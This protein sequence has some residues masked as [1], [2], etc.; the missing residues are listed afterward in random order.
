MANYCPKCPADSN[1][2]AHLVYST[3]DGDRAI[4]LLQLHPGEPTDDIE[5]TLIGSSLS[6]SKGKQVGYTALSYVWGDQA[7]PQPTILCNGA[8]LHIT[9]NLGAALRTLRRE[10]E[11]RTLWIDQICINQADLKERSA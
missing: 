4:R 7:L 10:E 8:I 9:S 2:G 3:L 5:C 11:Q 6:T 1:S